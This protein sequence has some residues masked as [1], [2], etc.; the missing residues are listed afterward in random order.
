MRHRWTSLFLI[1]GLISLVVACRPRLHLPFGLIVNFSGFQGEA[2]AEPLLASRIH[3]PEGFSINTY[4]GG[5]GSVRMLRFTASGDLLA[6][7]SR[8]DKVFLI[9]RDANG[10]GYADGKQILLDQVPQA[11]GLAL[12]DGWLYVGEGNAVARVRFDAESRALTGS[13]ER[14]VQGLPSG[15]NHWTRTVGIGPDGFLYV[16]VGSSCNVCIEEDARRAAIN[17]Y[18][19]DG[20]DG[21]VYASGLRNSVG[22]A[23]RPDRNELY[24]TDNGRDLLGDDFPPCEL[25]RVVEDGFYGWPLANGTNVPDPNYG[26]TNPEKLKNAIAPA[27]AFGAH[28][29]PLGITFYTGTQLPERYRGA[30]FVALHGSWN[31]SRKAGYKVVALLFQPDGSIVEEDFAVGFEHDDEV[32][33]RPVDIAVGPD[34]AL[35]VSDDYAGSVYRI[36]YQSAAQAGREVEQKGA[37]AGTSVAMLAPEIR[38]AAVQRGRLLWEQNPCRACHEPGAPAE[39]YKPIAHLSRKYAVESLALFLRTPQPPM[40]AFPFTDEQRRDL[41]IYLLATYP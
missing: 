34:G 18:R 41:A 33:G 31:R 35:Y 17:R 38:A 9:H 8:A 20:S 25:N 30:A 21:K 19:L 28:T 26:T 14:I 7:E 12:H 36:A 37:A 29:A 13:P 27:H 6:S 2:I 23:W 22:F 24:A 1:L 3:L 11:H 4:A 10:D 40:P 39:A 32:I 16:A 15:G 5:L